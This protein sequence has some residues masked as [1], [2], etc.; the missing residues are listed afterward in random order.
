MEDKQSFRDRIYPWFAPSDILSIELA[1]YLAKF[2]HRA[3]FRKELVDGKPQRYFEHVRRT[4]LILMDELKIMD[5]DMIVSALL[6][7]SIEDTQ[8]LSAELIEHCFN[9][10]VA[11]FVKLLSK[12]P[13]EGYYDRLVDCNNWKVLAIKVCDRIDNIRSLN[14]DGVSEE[15]KI[16]QKLQTKQHFR[17]VVF[18]FIELIPEEYKLN[19][20]SL[21]SEIFKFIG[22]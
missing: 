6:H 14:V 12:V 15:F 22:E 3:Q 17:K 11:L 5:R 16:K 10:D 21:K 4:S 1:Y 19:A 18:K 2:G 20:Y 9:K 8:D 7:D 13:A